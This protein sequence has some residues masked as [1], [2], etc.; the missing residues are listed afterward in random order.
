MPTAPP[1]RRRWF[2]F[3]I[4]EFLILTALLGVAWWQ[5]AQWPVMEFYELAGPPPDRIGVWIRE[6]THQETATRGMLASAV[7]IALWI[8]AG[9]VWRAVRARLRSSS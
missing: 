9:V 6:P 2:Q 3:S 5:A 4:M 8:A 1:K 7:I